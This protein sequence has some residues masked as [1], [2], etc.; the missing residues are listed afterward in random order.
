MNHNIRYEL[1][2]TDNCEITIEVQTSMGIM[3]GPLSSGVSGLGNLSPGGTGVYAIVYDIAEGLWWYNGG[4]GDPSHWTDQAPST[5]VPAADPTYETNYLWTMENPMLWADPAASEYP[6]NG[7]YTTQDFTEANQTLALKQAVDPI[8]PVAGGDGNGIWSAKEY[9]SKGYLVK[10]TATGL[11]GGAI[12]EYLQLMPGPIA[13]DV[14]QIYGDSSAA[15]TLS[16]FASNAWDST[17]SCFKSNVINAD[18]IEDRAIHATA[19]AGGAIHAG[20]TAVGLEPAIAGGA[21]HAGDTAVGFDPAIA[22]G[23]IHAG[24]EYVGGSPIA[25]ALA[26]NAIHAGDTA[27][28]YGSAFQASSIHSTALASGAIHA[29]TIAGGAIHKGNSVTDTPAIAEGAIHANNN[30]EG[31]SEPAIEEAAI[32][33]TALA[34]GAIHPTS[35]D[36]GAIHAET[37][38]GG[39]IHKGN[40]V[41]DT[42]AIAEGAIHANNN[43]E[44]S[45][46]PAIEEAAIHAAALASGAIHA[47]TIAGGAIHKGNSVTDTP[48]IAEGAIHANNNGE[49]SSGPA[50]EEA[51]I[52]ATALAENAINEQAIQIDSVTYEEISDSAMREIARAV[53]Q[54]S[55][56]S[57]IDG[58]RDGTGA[59]DFSGADMTMA[60]AGTMGHAMLVDH[61]SKY[62]VHTSKDI[63]GEGGTPWST[64]MHFTSKGDPSG[65]KFYSLSLEQT[66]LSPTEIASYIDRTAVLFRGMSLLSGDLTHTVVFALAA[67][68]ASSDGWEDATFNMYK[69]DG[70]LFY[71]KALPPGVD[72]DWVN[73]SLEPNTEYTWEITHGIDPTEIGLAAYIMDNTTGLWAL[74]IAQ[75]EGSL[76]GAG[77]TSGSFITG[78]LSPL[79]HQQH[80]VR[81]VGVERDDRGQY[82][83]IRCVDEDGSPVPMGIYPT[84]RDAKGDD[85]DILVDDVSPPFGDILII[86]A[87]TDATMHEVAHEV[88][89]EDV[90]DHSTPDTFGMLNRV[91]AGLS[92]FNHQ[93]TDSTYD[94]SGR[95]L[96]CRLV[97]YSNSEDARNGENALTTIEVK[98]T[99]DEKQNMTSFVA[100][101]EQTE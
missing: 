72:Q 13:A 63:T 94:E 6:F 12:T 20:D 55:I 22:G 8:D 99:Y 37:I 7:L 46:E 5:A 23:A 47:E 25:P 90:H 66:P 42:P 77:P 75:A 60:Q 86:K 74:P 95:L 93:I 84:K 27:F 19:I 81:I 28:P 15:E 45:S 65:E 51:A 64:P 24:G 71:T 96:A 1:R 36:D 87:E 54:S 52:H 29:E 56:F 3:P 82:F 34:E 39:A 80:L 41:T 32:H 4:V 61:L 50:I 73:L 92:Q 40:S 62:M 14:R 70:S 79:T 9:G 35:I 33:A 17:N 2:P 18:S 98:S 59:L 100:A 57:P 21:I 89:E 78:D 10:I 53:W 16:Y 30:G 68:D 38:A 26:E 44:G 58:S 88:W 48:A 67:T 97:V 85:F 101:E 43:G 31:S 69:P 76:F 49:G 11:P 83:K 91:V